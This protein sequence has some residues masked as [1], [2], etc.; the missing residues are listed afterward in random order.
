MI[1]LIGTNSQVNDVTVFVFCFVVV[2]FFW[3]G[4]GS[5]GF[6]FFWL[7]FFSCLGFAVVVGFF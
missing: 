2:F 5:A 4:G 7:V 6:C 1:L 3:W